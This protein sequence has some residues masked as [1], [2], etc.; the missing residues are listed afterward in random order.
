M[1]HP[2]I[3]PSVEIDWL[4][5][6]L[7]PFL[8]V[9]VKHNRNMS[10]TDSL[11]LPNI[12]TWKSLLSFIPHIRAIDAMNIFTDDPDLLNYGAGGSPSQPSPDFLSKDREIRT[13]FCSIVQKLTSLFPCSNCCMKHF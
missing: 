11:P 9:I 3:K 2:K 12:T 5:V 7:K 1:N 8:T 4:I 10:C 6:S 13:P